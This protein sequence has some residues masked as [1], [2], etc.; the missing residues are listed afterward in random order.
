MRRRHRTA[1]VADGSPVAPL[2]AAL[3][4]LGA[5]VHDPLV[6]VAGHVVDA[7]RAHA[8]LARAARLA[9]PQAVDLGLAGRRVRDR[10]LVHVRVGLVDV[11]GVGVAGV[12]VRIRH[13]LLPFARERPLAVAAEALPL[14]GAG[15]ARLVPGLHDRW[16]RAGL[17]RVLEGVDAVVLVGGLALA[18]RTGRKL[19]A[20]HLL[21]GVEPAEAGLLDVGAVVPFHLGHPLRAD[22]A[23]RLDGGRR[24]RRL[25]RRARLH[26][27]GFRLYGFLRRAAGVSRLGGRG[28]RVAGGLG[29]AVRVIAA[30][31]SEEDHPE[32]Q[33]HQP[34][35]SLR[36]HRR[37]PANPARRPERPRRNDVQLASQGL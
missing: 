34:T 28:V 29:D 16:L 33:T 22:A 17:V 21:F 9:L 35:R 11:A 4:G 8:R 10:L 6:D 37:P 26:L 19:R 13:P 1:A 36:L 2:E 24:G 25:D 15:V 23:E 20:A 5:L 7:V 27:V 32:H 12:A 18:A 31:R 14:G 3:V 30:A